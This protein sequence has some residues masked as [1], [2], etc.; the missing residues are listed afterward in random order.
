MKTLENA[1][2]AYSVKTGRITESQIFPV[3]FIRSWFFLPGSH[4][5]FELGNDPRMIVGFTSNRGGYCSSE[6]LA[7]KKILLYD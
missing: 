5:H 2:A 1:F 7:K 4:L 6:T 3:F